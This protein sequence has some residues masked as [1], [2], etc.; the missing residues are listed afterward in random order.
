M[1]RPNKP[2]IPGVDTPE[3]RTVLID[4]DPGID[5]AFALL[6]A[7][8][9]PSINLV[10]VTTVAGNQTLDHVTRNAL[11]LLSFFN[12]EH[13]PVAAGEAKPISHRQVTAQSH[14]ETGLGGHQL[15][16][17]SARLSPVDG[18]TTIID[19]LGTRPAKTV[20]LVA[21]GPLTN[22]ARA[23]ERDPAIA[24]RV[25]EVV[26]M[27]GANNAGNM[28]P[29]A[30]FNFYA[31]PEAADIVMRAGWPITMLGLNLTWQSAVPAKI[32]R[33]IDASPG[34]IAEAFSEWL[35]FYSRGEHTPDEDGPSLHDACAVAYVIDPSLV[36]TVPAFVAVETEGT[37]TYGESVVDL[38]GKYGETD[39]VNY[40]MTLDRDR[41]WDLILE[42]LENTPR[43]R[44]SATQ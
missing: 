42:A 24:E 38:D 31:D 11:G 36:D 13:I 44:P 14:G 40:G 8:A 35:T 17:G 5:D 22:L 34:P 29:V 6:L 41:F 9:N 27:G 26:I 1:D 21:I 20:T 12:A 16:P 37:W 18:V 10:A 23:V 33:H 32:Q 28:S 43:P 15:P 4:C 7:V 30:E 3:P 39:N 25:A 19:T 2:Q